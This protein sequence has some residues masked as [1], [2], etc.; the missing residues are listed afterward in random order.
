MQIEVSFRDL[1]S[2]RLC[3][4][5]HAHPQCRAARSAAADPHARHS[6]RL[7][8]G[9]GGNRAARVPF[10]Y[11]A[12]ASRMGIPALRQA[13]HRIATP[14]TLPPPA[15]RRTV[16]IG[17]I[18]C[19]ESSGSVPYYSNVRHSRRARRLTPFEFNHAR[20]SISANSAVILPIRFDVFELWGV[21]VWVRVGSIKV[22]FSR[23]PVI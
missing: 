23:I 19:G 22:R 6:R 16:R 15:A 21:K 7:A 1:K 13:P 2:V 3:V 4:R 5:G 17:T 20:P 12:A 14:R 11:L 8:G 9:A 10:L 18:K